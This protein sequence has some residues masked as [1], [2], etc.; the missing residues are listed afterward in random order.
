MRK[1]QRGASYS[2]ILFAVIVF[3][4]LA[5]FLVAVS[6]PYFD[7]RM[8]DSEISEVLK[9]SPS[10]TT[11]LKLNNQM[12][13]R[14]SMNNLDVKFEDIAKV[15]KDNQLV[16]KKNYE[17]RKPFFLNIDLVLKFEKNFDQSSVKAK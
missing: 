15:T 16:V 13:Q 3:V 6:G 7:D 11:P 8:I 2:S 14:F 10:D 1:S 12:N 9:N 5:K 17:V 4:L